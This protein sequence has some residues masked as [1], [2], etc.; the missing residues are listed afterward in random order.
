MTARQRDIRMLQLTSKELSE[1]PSETPV[2]EGVGK[3]YVF[4]LLS[5]SSDWKSVIWSHLATGFWFLFFWFSS[6]SNANL[7]RLGSS[8]SPSI[9]ST[10]ASLV[11]ARKRLPK[12]PIW[13]RSWNTMRLPTGPVA[14]TWSRFLSP[15]VRHEALT[16]VD[17]QA[18]YGPVLTRVSDWNEDWIHLGDQFQHV[19]LVFCWATPTV[20][21]LWC[22]PQWG[23]MSSATTHPKEEKGQAKCV[24]WIW[25]EQEV[26]FTPLCDWY[27]TVSW[28]RGTARSIL[29]TWIPGSF[30]NLLYARWKYIN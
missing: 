16:D 6:L 8:T 12:S 25:D 3:M 5:V 26:K 17:K 23:S 28:R 19:L 9:P 18:F 20:M 13:K 4:R 14:T 2:Y 7:P 24:Y 10:S 22:R 21:T 29:A 27:F 15:E 11:K 1:L 30:L